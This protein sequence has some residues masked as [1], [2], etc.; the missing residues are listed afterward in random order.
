MEMTVIYQIGQLIGMVILATIFVVMIKS[1]VKIL[2]VQMDGMNDNL[3]LLNSSFTKLSEVLSKSEVQENRISRA[4]EDIRELRHGRGFVQ[5]DI[6][7][8]YGSRGKKSSV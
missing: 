4:E 3:K 8:E 7:G 5:Q 2:K 1:D 6:N